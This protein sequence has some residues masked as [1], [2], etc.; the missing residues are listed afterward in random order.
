MNSTVWSVAV[1]AQVPDVMFLATNL[2][3]LFRSDD[4]GL[5]W[6][7]LQQEF[8]EIRALHWRPLPADS[9]KAP[10]SL[11]RAVVRADARA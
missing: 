4:A 5:R 3:Q 8:G 6:T 9:R 7:R 1:N 11:T 10:H 2:G